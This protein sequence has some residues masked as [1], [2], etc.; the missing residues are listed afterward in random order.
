[1][2]LEI[3]SF[4]TNVGKDTT[5]GEV[6]VDKYSDVLRVLQKPESKST[7]LIWNDGAQQ[8]QEDPYS[9]KILALL[10]I[11]FQ[12]LRTPFTHAKTVMSSW[13]D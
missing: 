3:L 11:H 8:E 7:Y 13:F 12:E 2:S 10:L 9:T 1:M 6:Y 4:F 5:Q